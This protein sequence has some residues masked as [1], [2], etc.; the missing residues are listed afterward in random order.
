MRNHKITLLNNYYCNLE[1]VS[2]CEGEIYTL[3]WVELTGT[4]IGGEKASQVEREKT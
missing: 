2:L 4:Q 3:E 1:Y